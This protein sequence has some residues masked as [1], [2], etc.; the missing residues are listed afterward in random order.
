MGVPVHN[1]GGVHLNERPEAGTTVEVMEQEAAL[2]APAVVAAQLV[3]VVLLLK[4]VF[5]GPLNPT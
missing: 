3:V 4:S 5:A 1:T 2:V